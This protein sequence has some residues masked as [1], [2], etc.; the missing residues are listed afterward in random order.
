MIDQRSTIPD[1]AF[2]EQLPKSDLHLH[3]DGSL[4]LETLIELAREQQVELPSNTPEGLRELVFK[5]HYRDLPEYLQG[6]KYTV[7][8]LRERESLERAAYEL[9]RDNQEEGVCYIEVR[10]APQLHLNHQLPMEEIILAVD[11]GLQRAQR[12]YNREPLV[13]QGHRPRFEYGLILCALRF[14]TAGFSP[15]YLHF[16]NAHKYSNPRQVYALA[17]LELARAATAIKK[18]RPEV[19]IVG[20]DLAGQ[21]EGY[22]AGDHWQGYQQAHAHFLGKTVHAGE[23]YGP[24]SIFQAITELH[25]DRIGHG[26]WLFDTSRIKDPK[27]D[28]PER[29]VQQLADFIAE[30]RI[31]LEI[32]LTS[33]LQTLPEIERLENHP[34]G[35]MLENKLS[36]TFCTDNRLVSRTSVTGEILKAVETF[37]I[38]ASQLK[39]LIAYGFKRSFFPGPYT[40]KRDY[41]RHVL[42][43]YEKLLR[44]QGGKEV[45]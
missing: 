12:E 33:N 3:L 22:P 41:V 1:R 9:A 19:P 38:G 14:F 43:Y 11:R 34:F 6:F 18:S 16:F 40:E 28:D 10:F 13:V 29:Y 8:V 4:R 31:T 44:E 45:T 20:F 21:E 5:E 26:T 27:I 42:D 39:D 15:N 30:R 23:A 2:I 35:R 32:C 36:T 37:R 17:S 25:A 24:E 7:T